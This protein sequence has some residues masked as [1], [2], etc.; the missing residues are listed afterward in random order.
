VPSHHPLCS[1]RPGQVIKATTMINKLRQAAVACGLDPN[2]MGP[3]SL[4]SG[5]ATAMLSAG[6]D[7]QL[8][9]LFGRWASDSVDRYTRLTASA[10]KTLSARMAAR[11]SSC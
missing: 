10:T 9:K 2:R 11:V 4:R 7:Q 6:V 5:G 3:H 1:V 8:I